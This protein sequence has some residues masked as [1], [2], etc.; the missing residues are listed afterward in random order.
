MATHRGREDALV[1]K[2]LL[3]FTST[4]LKFKGLVFKALGLRFGVLGFGFG[5]QGLGLFLSSRKESHQRNPH[6]GRTSS[7]LSGFKV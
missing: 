6:C 1:G 4:G 3:F 7:A 5:V 2:A